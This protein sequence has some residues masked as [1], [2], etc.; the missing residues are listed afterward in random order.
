MARELSGSETTEIE[1]Y[2]KS[3]IKDGGDFGSNRHHCGDNILGKVNTSP[4]DIEIGSRLQRL[5]ISMS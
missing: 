1:D 5:P 4:A 3:L 2:L